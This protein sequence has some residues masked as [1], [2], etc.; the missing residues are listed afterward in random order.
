MPYEVINPEDFL[1]EKRFTQEIF[2]G[3]ISSFD[4]TQFT[5]KKVLIRGCSGAI[6]PPW[7]YMLITA[8]LVGIAQS[9]RYGNE[10]DNIVVYRTRYTEAIPKK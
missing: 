3:N 2:L 1:V 7:A 5:G 4:W 10:H 6:I 9:I 8:K